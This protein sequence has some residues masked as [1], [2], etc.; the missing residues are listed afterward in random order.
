[1]SKWILDASHSEVQFKIRH[2][3]ISNVTGSFNDFSGEIESADDAFSDLKTS[4]SASVASIDTNQAQRDEHLKS[5]DFFA[6]ATFPN[7][8]FSSNEKLQ[9]S[10]DS[11]IL[12]GILSIRGIEK[13]VQLSV[14]FGGIAKDGYGQ[15]KA[16]FE[17]TGKISRKE[18]GLTWSALT[19]TGGLMVG[20]EVKLMLNMQFVKQA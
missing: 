5:D 3:V 1:M 8:T 17:I 11:H 20:D 15:I 12:N 18:F 6:A 13:P 7:I 4:F 9:K 10:G 19:E 2:L 14:D 16:G